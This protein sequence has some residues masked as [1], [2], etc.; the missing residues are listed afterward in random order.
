MTS[1]S[2]TKVFFENETKIFSVLMVPL[3]RAILCILFKNN[4]NEEEHQNQ[5]QVGDSDIFRT[6]VNQPF[7]IDRNYIVDSFRSNKE[8]RLSRPQWRKKLMVI[9]CRCTKLKSKPHDLDV[10]IHQR[11]YLKKS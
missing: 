5:L 1:Y 6:P 8:N 2:K 11:I 10:V 3:K 4:S 7:F 9:V